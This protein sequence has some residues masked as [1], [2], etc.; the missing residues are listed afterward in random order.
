MLQR[1]EIIDPF[2][3]S[4]HDRLVEEIND[5]VDELTEGS[6]KLTE[7]DRETV[8]EKYAARVAHIKALRRVLDVCAELQ[9][10]MYGPKGR[11]QN[12]TGES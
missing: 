8:A 7:H 5:K 1:S 6:A 9:L 2:F 4:L 11:D 10:D 12:Q 3:R